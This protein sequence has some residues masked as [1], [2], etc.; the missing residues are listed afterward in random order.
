M[1]DIVSQ[2][3]PDH[4][5]PRPSWT[6]DDHY[7]PENLHLHDTGLHSSVKW[8]KIIIIKQPCSGH[9]QKERERK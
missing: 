9:R 3:A 7:N 4:E 1:I 8:K 2:L 6:V 5:D